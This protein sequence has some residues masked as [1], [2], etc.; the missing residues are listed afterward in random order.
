[1]DDKAQKVT[2]LGSI[3]AAIV[4]STCCVGPVIFALLG[5]SS[6]GLLTKMEPYRPILSIFTL[7]LLG[8]A[9]YF[10]YR[11]KP[12]EEC[13]EGSYCANPKSDKWNKRI[14]WMATIFIIGFLTFPY[15]S[16]Y[17]V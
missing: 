8:I 16:I 3:I 15:W 6:A 5:V 14:L 9:F 2:L 17:L 7:G 12:S 13:E 11:K 1:M 10:S 4:A